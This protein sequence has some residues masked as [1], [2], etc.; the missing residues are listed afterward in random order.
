MSSIKDED[1]D[2]SGDLR[3]NNIEEELMVGESSSCQTF[4]DVKK[5]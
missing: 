2:F 5:G 1:D 4:S 3:S